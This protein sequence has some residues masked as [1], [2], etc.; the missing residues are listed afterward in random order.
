MRIASLVAFTMTA[1]ISLAADERESARAWHRQSWVTWSNRTGL[2]I[3]TIESLWHI[4]VGPHGEDE[5][6]QGIENIDAQTL[7]SRKQILFVV[8]A[9]NGHCLDVIVFG[10]DGQK[11]NLIWRL[12]E[13]PEGGGICHERMLAYPTAYAQPPGE[14]VVQIPTGA[15]WVAR[16]RDDPGSAYPVSTALKVYTYRWNGAEYK[17]AATQKLVTYDSV[18]LNPE[19]CTIDAPC[20]Q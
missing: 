4:A 17:L 10:N 8:S 5:F 2:N 20:T 19:K 1:V 15:A 3:E 11:K 16:K 12:H 13:L 7:R 14:I 9:G 18:T 6:E